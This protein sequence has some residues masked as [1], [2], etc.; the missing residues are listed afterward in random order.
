MTVID[1]VDQHKDKLNDLCRR[2]HVAELDV[3]GSA[4][5]DDFD[6][7]RS[8]LDFLVEF[9]ESVEANRFD[10]FFGLRAD[11]ERLFGRP[12]DL[13]E[14]EG[15]RNPYFIQTVNRTRRRLYVAP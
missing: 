7:E 2:Y 13:V 9:D 8:D 5:G 14:P 10:A 1:V 12:V 11:L 3:F 4:A 15:L 6:P